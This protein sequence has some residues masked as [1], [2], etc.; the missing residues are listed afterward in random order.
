MESTS[1]LDLTI[2]QISYNKSSKIL[3]IN[4]FNSMFVGHYKKSVK[5]GALLDDIYASL[6]KTELQRNNLCFLDANNLPI[7]ENSK[8]KDLDLKAKK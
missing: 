5:I 7:S 2:D 3:S 6:G 1:K 4:V 8:L